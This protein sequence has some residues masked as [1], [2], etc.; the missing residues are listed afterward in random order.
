MRC[1][2][3]MESIFKRRFSMTIKEE[4]P[5]V[6]YKNYFVPPLK[7]KKKK[8]KSDCFVVAI[9]YMLLWEKETFFCFIEKFFFVRLFCLFLYLS[10]CL[11]L[12]LYVSPMEIIHLLV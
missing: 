1:A 9:A 11:S 6:S 7:R 3:W 2:F 8:Q 10:H 12:L 5:I 4:T